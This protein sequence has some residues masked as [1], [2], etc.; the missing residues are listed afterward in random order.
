MVIRYLGDGSF[1]I[2]TKVADIAVGPTTRIGELTLTGP[3]EYE[4][5]DVEAQGFKDAYLFL[6]ED[7]TVLY[8][9]NPVGLSDETAKSLDADVDILLLTAD[10]NPSNLKGAVKTL[11]DIDPKIA[12]PTIQTQHHPLCKEIGGCPAPVNELKVSKKD[13]T[14][15][16]RV[17]LL[18]ARARTRR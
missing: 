18:H 6:V 1:L 13:L 12:L 8:V 7:M 2:E 14:E 15:E 4:V 5:G 10:E 17:I 9:N 16:R 11:N 3:G